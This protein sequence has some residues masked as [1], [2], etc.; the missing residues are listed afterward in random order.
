MQ[1]EVDWIGRV[2]TQRL[3]ASLA[4][5]AAVAAPL[6]AQAMDDGTSAE[7]DPVALAH[8]IARIG[9]VCLVAPPPGDLLEALD[10][11]LLPVLDPDL[12]PTAPPTRSEEL[13]DDRHRPDDAYDPRLHDQP[14]VVDPVVLVDAAGYAA[15]GYPHA[16]WDAL[17]AAVARAL[18]RAP[19]L[20]AVLGGHPPRGRPPPV[21]PP[22][23]VPQR[24]P[25]DPLPRRRS[26]CATGGGSQGRSL[27]NM[28]PPEHRDYRAL[29]APFLKPSAI[30]SLEATIRAITVDLLDAAPQDEPFDFVFDLAAYH[31]LKVICGVLGAAPEDQDLVLRIAN[32]VFGIEDPDY[33]PQLAAL[34][35]EMMEYYR[36][37]KEDRLAQ[38]TDDLYSALVH[39]QIDGQPI[40]D[41]ELVSYFLI[42]TSA[43]HDTTR[44]A[45][46]GGL[47]A[48]L[49]HPDQLELLR[50]DPSRCAHRRRRDHPVDHPGDP[51]LPHARR[52]P[53]ARRPPDPGGRDDGDVL[54]VGQPRR[55]GVRGAARVPRHP[56]PQPPPRPRRGR[57]LLPRRPP[58]PH[59]DPHPA[60]GARPPARAHRAR[61]ARRAH[62]GRLRRRREAPARP[63]V[64]PA[65][66]RSLISRPDKEHHRA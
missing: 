33:G 46:A 26:S 34:A 2:A 48:L 9:M 42:L 10:A 36:R 28:D 7:Q 51:V 37:L 13:A 59:R 23:P 63:V 38:P 32:T 30:R 39:S 21:D 8:W 53:R 50:E 60:R 1:D 14:D 64:A 45:L 52:R 55:G 16:A 66:R 49:E 61:R 15:H 5:S 11:L 4:V 56:R 43:G 65:D 44:N 25:H 58:R 17:R 40:G 18:V 3:E 54:P 24:A 31:P 27:I 12:A 57:A 35:M 20:P 22:G 47:L 19:R 41:M 62:R 6:L 29:A